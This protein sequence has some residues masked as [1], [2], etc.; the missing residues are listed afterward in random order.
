MVKIL[1]TECNTT[2]VVRIHIMQ[3]TISAS[4]ERERTLFLLPFGEIDLLYVRS[5]ACCT[6]SARVYIGVT[7]SERI[8]GCTGHGCST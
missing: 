7:Y 2:A 5:C 8:S 3:K 1:C 4:L 6:T